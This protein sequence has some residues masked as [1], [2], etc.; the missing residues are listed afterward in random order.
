MTR[1]QEDAW[2]AALFDGEG[3]YSL[4]RNMHDSG[5]T[6]K[7][8]ITNT[9]KEL[10]LKIQEVVGYGRIVEVAMSKGRRKPCYYWVCVS[11][12]LDDFLIRV[13]P[14]LIAKREVTHIVKALRAIPSSH[15]L[16]ET[17]PAR[18]L[19]REKLI[20]EWKS[21]YPHTGAGV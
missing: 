17:P 14:Y 7:V 12:Q 8:H 4:Q 9:C 18:L 19:L 1:E 6:L 15:G 16:K 3:G 21:K 10:L 20:E 2:L 5:I 11:K 13:E